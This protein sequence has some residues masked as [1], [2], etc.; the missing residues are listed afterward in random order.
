MHQIRRFDDLGR[1]V[2]PKE[3]REAVIHA[4][5]TEGVQMD[6]DVIDGAIVLKPHKPKDMVEVVRCKDCNFF[7]DKEDPTYPAGKWESID[8]ICWRDRKFTCHDDYCSLGAKMDGDDNEQCKT[9]A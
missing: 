2:I 4:K 7:I 5:N 3:M 9:D 1:I 8:G 6:V